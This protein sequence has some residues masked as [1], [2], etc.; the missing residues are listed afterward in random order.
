MDKYEKVREQILIQIQQNLPCDADTNVIIEA[1]KRREIDFLQKF[2]SYSQ[3]RIS[4]A[5]LNELKGKSDNVEMDTK[6]K[7]LIKEFCKGSEGRTYD[8]SPETVQEISKFIPLLPRC[9]A[10]FAVSKFVENL[11]ANYQRLAGKVLT[12]QDYLSISKSYEKGREQLK[13]DC[14]TEFLRLKDKLIEGNVDRNKY[15]KEIEKFLNQQ[16]A[17]IQ[18]T[19]SFALQQKGDKISFVIIKLKEYKTKKM[20]SDAA[21]A[22]NSVEQGVKNSNSTDSDVYWLFTFYGLRKR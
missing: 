20:A 22:A 12:Q 5:A 18:G 4:T 14:E 19:L 6:T 11:I 1:A 9:I 7:S 10:T 16:L 3:L 13:V 2:K 17:D 15:F 21:I 8:P